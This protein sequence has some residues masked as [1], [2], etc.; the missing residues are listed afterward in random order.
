MKTYNVYE[1]KTQLSRILDAVLNGEEVVIGRNG[2]PLVRMTKFEE[3]QPDRVLGK[4]AGQFKLTDEFFEPLPEEVLDLFYNSADIPN[5]M[6]APS[7]KKQK[8]R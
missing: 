6:P 3:R 5:A 8:K 2:T 4:F 7:T 1:A